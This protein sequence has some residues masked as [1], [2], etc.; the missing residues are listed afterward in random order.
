MIPCCLLDHLR[1]T[2]IENSIENKVLLLVSDGGGNYG[3]AALRPVLDSATRS[4]A[5]IYTIVSSLV[6]TKTAGRAF[7]ANW[8]KQLAVGHTFHLTQKGVHKICREIAGD[9]R[10]RARSDSCRL[11][12]QV[13]TDF[14]RSV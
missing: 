9:I 7:F 11:A 2:R 3:R 14:T 12:G 6:T 13:R 1:K 4:E 10:G 5:V 8:Q